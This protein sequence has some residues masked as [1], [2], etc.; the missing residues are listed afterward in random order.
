MPTLS[1]LLTQLESAVRAG[2]RAGTFELARQIQQQ[3]VRDQH[4]Q[5]AL[6]RRVRELLAELDRRATRVHAF[7]TRSPH[8][9][10]AISPVAQDGVVYPDLSDDTL[11]VQHS[12]RQER[13]SF[14]AEIRN[15]L[16]FA[17]ESGDSPHALFFQ[18]GFNVSFEEAAIRAA[19]IGFDLKVPGATAFWKLRK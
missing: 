18:H 8:I 5:S 4:A 14:F 2:D 17:R 11:R 19:Q 10:R 12:E 1:E 7:D 13:E 3:L 6:E 15:V 16:Q 9:E